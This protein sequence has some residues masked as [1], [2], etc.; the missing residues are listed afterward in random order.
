MPI[1]EPEVLIEGSRHRAVR[2]VTGRV[3]TRF[4]TRFLIRTSLSKACCSNPTWSSP[5]CSAPAGVGRRGCA[6][7]GALSPAAGAGRG[8]RHRLFVGGPGSSG[9]DRAS[10]RDQSRSRDHG[11]DAQFFV[12][13]RT[14]GRGARVVAW[15]GAKSERWPA[16]LLSS[17]QVRQ[18]GRTGQYTAS[19]ESES[20]R[21]QVNCTT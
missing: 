14:P 5:V 18:R 11:P 19:M 20:A 3:C 16:R 17:R 15:K 21:E 10:E 2:E 6:C 4:S 8:A 1:V 9:R 12:W 7:D 13:A